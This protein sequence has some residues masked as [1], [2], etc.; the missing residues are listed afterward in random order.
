VGAAAWVEGEGGELVGVDVVVL[1]VGD[2]DLVLELLD[3]GVFGARVDLFE[4]QVDADGLDGV[5]E[6]LSDRLVHLV[7]GGDG[8]LELESVRELR[9]RELGLRLGD[10]VPRPGSRRV[11]AGQS[12]TQEAPPRLPVALRRRRHAGRGEDR[13]NRGRRNGDA[14]LAQ[15]ADDPQV[16]PAWV[17][18]SEPPQELA[19]VTARTGRANAVRTSEAGYRVPGAGGE[20]GPVPLPRCQSTKVKT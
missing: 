8:H 1:P 17:L 10:V 6:D 2:A 18:A 12:R 9:L 16:A 19:H 20:P 3:V 14:E 4:G 11:V 13:A 5:L 15:L 7:A